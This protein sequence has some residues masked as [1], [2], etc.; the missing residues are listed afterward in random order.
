M[1]D[2]ALQVKMLILKF[3]NTYNFRGH[4]EDMSLAMTQMCIYHLEN[5]RQLTTNEKSENEKKRELG[6]L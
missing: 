2:S 4:F 5:L 6:L 1:T 3:S